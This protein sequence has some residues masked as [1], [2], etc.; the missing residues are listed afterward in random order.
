MA[1][2]RARED[3]RTRGSIEAET[4][5]AQLEIYELGELARENAHHISQDGLTLGPKGARLYTGGTSEY[6]AP[7]AHPVWSD[8]LRHESATLRWMGEPLINGWPYNAPQP[9]ERE[10]HDWPSAY[11]PVR[12]LSDE[13]L[14]SESRERMR[15]E[16][17]PLEQRRQEHEARWAVIEQK[18][19]AWDRDVSR[20][21]EEHTPAQEQTRNRERGHAR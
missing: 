16:A 11:V 15:R 2:Q 10:G 21:I 13:A 19:A 7:K 8:E 5:T 18:L 14:S 4:R 17:L 6:L 12:D 9:W 1:E 20:Y 3:L